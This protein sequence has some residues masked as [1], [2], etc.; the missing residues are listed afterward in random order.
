MGC[1]GSKKLWDTFETT[2]LDIVLQASQQQ[3]QAQGH[4]GNQEVRHWP[5]PRGWVDPHFMTRLYQRNRGPPGGSVMFPPLFGQGVSRSFSE[6][7]HSLVDVIEQGWMGAGGHAPVQPQPPPNAAA[8]AREPF[9]GY[10][11]YRRT[12]H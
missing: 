3:Q 1:E 5:P 12:C 7:P 2:T 4:R 9:F 10:V 8:V 6:P 11:N